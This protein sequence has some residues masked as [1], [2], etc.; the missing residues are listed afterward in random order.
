[1]LEVHGFVYFFVF[2]G[3]SSAWLQDHLTFLLEIANQLLR[4][5]S[6]RFT[7]PEVIYPAW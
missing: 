3:F 6:P 2:L 1:M 7:I 4:Q 5:K